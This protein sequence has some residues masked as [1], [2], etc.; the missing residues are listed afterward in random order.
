MRLGQQLY[1]L[2]SPRLTPARARPPTAL[3][4][5]QGRQRFLGQ[6]QPI[7]KLR[8][9][10]Q[11]GA[12][13]AALHPHAR[14]ALDCTARRARAGGGARGQQAGCA[15]MPA[16]AGCAR[17]SAEALAVRRLVALHAPHCSAA[18]K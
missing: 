11:A 15:S 13:L 5:G 17:A 14:P 8:R 3:L 1:R 6:R 10:V 4:L 2:T 18:M 9:Q 7:D 12:A 16:L